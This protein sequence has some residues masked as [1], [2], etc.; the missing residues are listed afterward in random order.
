M[1]DVEEFRKA[2]KTWEAKVAY[3][4]EKFPFTRNSDEALYLM[5]IKV[6]YPE[7]MK[8]LGIVGLHNYV[9]EKFVKQLPKFETISR[10]RRRLQNDLGLYLPTDPEVLRRR[11]RG[12]RLWRIVMS[13]EKNSENTNC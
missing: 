8:K 7:V 1:D 12:E 5:V 2:Y 9:P 11:I 4:L 6:F 3:V 10:A 13:L